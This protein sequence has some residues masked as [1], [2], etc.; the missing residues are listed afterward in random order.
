MSTSALIDWQEYTQGQEV[1]SIDGTLDANVK[2]GYMNRTL[3]KFLAGVA[4]FYSTYGVKDSSC[5]TNLPETCAQ[6]MCQMR[7]AATHMSSESNN[8]AD[9]AYAR[10]VV[11]KLKQFHAEGLIP[12]LRPQ[13]LELEA[14]LAPYPTVDRVGFDVGFAEAVGP[15][16]SQPPNLG[17]TDYPITTFAAIHPAGMVGHESPPEL[18]QTA[19]NTI[20]AVNADN[21]WQ[22]NNG[23]CLA[24][25]V[26]ALLLRPNPGGAHS[27]CRSDR[28]T[29][30]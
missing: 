22:P 1:S 17:N 4:D 11:T 9:L 2:T 14:S 20:W 8:N 23:F 19:R 6:E 28:V 15:G 21:S 30:D 26:P 7:T 16:G 18:L 29:R 24:W 27:P 13:W 3:F 12:N 25:P 5:V 10:M